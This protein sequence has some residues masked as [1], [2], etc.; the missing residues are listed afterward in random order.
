MKIYV[1]LPI[2]GY[3][4]EER[5]TRAAELKRRFEREGHEAVTP[6]DLDWEEGKD[7]AHYMGKD[8]EALLRCDPCT[9]TGA[10]K[11]R[12]D[13]GSNTGRQEYLK[14]R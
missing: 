12:K 8:I 7:Y 6:F 10:G 11:N 14:G 2:T 3:D 5:K 4:I 1:S 9:S 13:A